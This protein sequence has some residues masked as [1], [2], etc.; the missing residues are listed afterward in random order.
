M[1]MII[2]AAL[3]PPVMKDTVNNAFRF[4]LQLS[5]EKLENDLT[6][7]LRESWKEHFN[8]RDY[9]GE[10]SAIALRSQTGSGQDIYARV[11]EA[12]FADTPLMEK[13]A[14]FREIVNGFQ[15]EKET[16]RLLRLKPGS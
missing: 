14:Y 9:S 1:S 15:F 12:P 4:P 5:N 10:W 2:C 13:C 8:A 3:M 16:V 7:C 11:S 6:V